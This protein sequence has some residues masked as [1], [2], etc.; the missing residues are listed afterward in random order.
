MAKYSIITGLHALKVEHSTKR[1]LMY[2]EA[3]QVVGQAHKKQSQKQ[4]AMSVN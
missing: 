2:T 1:L 3:L 4:L